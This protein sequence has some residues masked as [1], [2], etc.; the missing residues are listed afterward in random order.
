MADPGARRGADVQAAR[1]NVQIAGPRSR[2][3]FERASLVIPGGVDSPVRAFRAVGGS[4]WFVASGDGAHVVDVDGTR[5]LDY[6]QSWGA[7]ILGHAHPALVEAVRAAAGRGTTFGA[8]TEGEVELAERVTA[9][10]P[11]CEM[12]RFVSSGTEAA[13][14]A[15]RLARGATGR[16]RIVKFAGCYHGHSDGLLAAGGSGVATLGL[17]DSA[18]VPAGAVADTV[19]AP[20]NTVPDID[21]RVACVVVEPVAANMGLVA[22]APGFLDGLRRACDEAGALLVFDEVITGFRLGRDGASGR[23]GVRPDLWC[24][25]KV[26]GGGLPLAALGGRRELMEVLAPSGP[27]YQAGTLSGNPLATAA[28]IAALDLLD[29]EAYETLAERVGRLASGLEGAFDD[30]GVVAQV[31]VVGTLLGVFF[32]DEPVGNYEDARRAAANGHYARF[33]TSM[34][35]RAVALAPSPYEVLFTSLAHGDAEIDLTIEAAAASAKELA[36]S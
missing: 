20:Y 14:T 9:S 4:P 18:G 17:P 26:V 21:E 35:R 10:V 30:A 33:F 3:L 16:D 11:G 36:A 32:A 28:G 1:E 5:Y 23:F 12:V 7:S 2:E 24:F 19:V 13:M 15:V 34:A 22:P 31:P 25:G 8:P 6:V 29:A 27:V